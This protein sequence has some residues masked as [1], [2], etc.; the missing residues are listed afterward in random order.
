MG[1]LGGNKFVL[2]QT[3]VLGTL[4]LGT[5]APAQ[6]LPLGNTTAAVEGTQIEIMGGAQSAD[7]ENLF[8]QFESFNVETLETVTFIAPESVDNIFGRIQG[9]QISTIDGG[10]AVSNQANLWLLNPA[11]I[12]FGANAHLNLQGDFN[13]ATAESVGFAQGWWRDTAESALAGAPHSIG[14]GANP[15]TLINLGKLQVTP[16]QTLRLLGGSVVNRGSA[17]AP[18]GTITIA[19]IADSSR[20]SLSQPGQVL[21]LEIDPWPGSAQNSVQNSEVSLNQLPALLTGQGSS[22]ADSLTVAADGT[23]QLVQSTMPGQVQVSGTVSSAGDQGGEIAILGDQ[24]ALVDAAIAADGTHQG[25]HIYIG[26][27]YQGAGPLPNATHT[28]VDLDTTL[29]ANALQ[30]GNGG[31]VI[32]WADQATDFRGNVQAQGGTFGGDGGFIEVS[33]KSELSFTGQFSLSAPRG[34][35][36]TI[37]FDP[38]NIRIIEGGTPADVA[39]ESALFPAVDATDLDIG[40]LTLHAATLESW[41]G[42]DNIILQANLNIDIDLGGNNSLTFQPGTGSITFIADANGNNTGAF[43]MQRTGDELNTSGRDINIHGAIASLESIDTSGTTG[44]GDVHIKA[45]FLTTVKGRLNADNIVVRSNE[46]NL[47]GGIGSVSGNTLTIEPENPAIEITI[48]A[49]NNTFFDLALLETD[50]LAL[51]DGFNKI[52]IGR[53]DGSHDVTLYDAATDIGTATFQDAVTIVGANV[54]TGP[55]RLTHWTITDQN[56]GNLDHRF[57]HGLSF[58][59]TSAIIPGSGVNALQGDASNDVITFSGLNAG[60]FNG[61]SFTNMQTV[62][63]AEGDDQFIF[64]DGSSIAGTLTGGDGTDTINYA[65]YT[66]D[67][68]VDLQTNSATGTGGFNSVES[69]M[70]GNSNDTFKLSANTVATSISGGAGNNLLIGDNVASTWNLTAANTGTGTGVTSFDTIQ[71]L[72]AGNQSDQINFLV[73]GARFTG[74][75]NGGDDLLTLSGDNIGIGT[76]V[77]GTGA[78]A[79]QPSSLDRNIRLGGPDLASALSLSTDELAKIDDSFTAIT[80]G[81][82]EGTGQITLG[83]DIIF[84]VPTTVQ[85]PGENGLINTQGFNLAASELTLSAAQAIDTADLTAPLGVQLNSRGA[86]TTQH[87]T[88]SDGVDGGP[89]IIDAGTTVTTGQINTTGTTGAGGDIK[90]NATDT[91][92]VHTIQAEGSTA[93]GTVSIATDRFLRA[94]G[95]FL[96]LDGTTASISTAAANGTG[97]IT[98]SHGGNGVTPFEI[99]NSH[100][101]GSEA[102]I[103]TGNHQLS[104]GEAF[105]SS[106]TLGNIALLTADPIDSDVTTSVDPLP[107]PNPA[108]KNVDPIPELN[109]VQGEYTV[110][111]LK[112]GSPQLEN[113]TAEAE[114]FAASVSPDDSNQA[115]FEQL[116]S[117]Y[118][119]QFKSHLNLYERVSVSPVDLNMARQTLRN[120]ET[121]TG[122]KP[123]VLYVYF[124]PSTEKAALADSSNLHPNDELELLLLTH[125]GQTVRQKIAGVT[126]R[127]VIAAAEELHGQVTNV[128]SSPSQYLP[129]AQRLYDWLITPIEDELQTQRIQ[130]LAMVMDTGLR[131]LPVAALHSGE[132]FL[133]ERYSVGVIPSFSLTD[134]NPQNFLYTQ[135]ETTQLLA[136]GASLFPSQQRLPAVPEELEIVTKAFRNSKIFLNE[137]FTLDNLQSQVA[138]NQF[139][140]VHLASHGVFEPGEPENSYIQLWDQPLQ[141]DQ[142]HTLGLQNNDIALMVLSACNTALGDQQAEYGFAGLAVNAGV[143]TAVASLWPISDEG[144]L[145]LMTYF[146]ERLQQQPVRAIALRHA[147]LAMLQGDLTFSNGTLYGPDQRA[148]AHFPDLEYHGRWNFAHPFYWSTYTLVGSPW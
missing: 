131:T 144:T 21:A 54:L 96:S 92:Q 72:T 63:G 26:G 46:L 119:E 36:G 101:L 11:G 89:V 109:P 6:I 76:A 70:G 2:L 34:E 60:T 44:A 143:Q 55:D 61:I 52:T 122:I 90:L 108:Q 141:L 138:R 139:G 147:Q 67:I 98:I 114:E 22:H 5:A 16:G 49:T 41:S 3:A 23:L 43:T 69:F 121:V 88:T 42:N 31:Q 134:F 75:L 130:S 85:S 107:A 94:V 127:D 78:L 145:G 123:G 103:T 45:P 73:D 12:F 77:K 111:L 51:Q 27:S 14:F 102:N 106:Y 132:E 148:L 7:G 74:E 113:D 15:G 59:N 13:A 140:I 30:K 81:H 129:P 19:A 39:T 126:R 28:S 95:S 66:T 50:I 100:R 117:S 125:D 40:T 65:D 57:S 1:Q 35:S 37:L 53:A 120:V 62:D 10:L 80:I 93:G 58:E 9:G 84:P 17:I 4:M 110:P 99:G 136:M 104:V 29:S 91:I 124:L 83:A 56:Q 48:G 24:I 18:A 32:V 79:I 128:I 137:E 118:S 8:H 142:I 116:E 71:N 38:S 68:V 135:L 115:L 97:N 20:L 87:I 47:N 133:I 64:H 33:G 86:V 146:Y 105:L 112:F 25:G 82:P